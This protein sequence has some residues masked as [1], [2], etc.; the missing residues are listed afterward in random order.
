[1][2]V[3]T[4][5]YLVADNELEMS[6]IRDIGK[7]IFSNVEHNEGHCIIDIL[8][9]TKQSILFIHIFKKFYLKE[10]HFKK[11]ENFYAYPVLEKFLQRFNKME[12]Y[13]KTE[14]IKILII[15]GHSCGWYVYGNKSP[16]YDSK[17][18]L[19]LDDV[20]HILENNNLYLDA[21]SFD[22]C[23]GSNLEVI[24]ELNQ[25][26]RFIIASPE[27]MY[28][29]GICNIEFCQHLSKIKTPAD[30][31]SCLKDLVIDL[32]Q[33]SD[34]KKEPLSLSLIDNEKF[35]KILEMIKKVKFVQDD[36]MKKDVIDKCSIWI[37]ECSHGGTCDPNECEVFYDLYNVI[38]HIAEKDPNRIN[39]REFSEIYK[40][41]VDYS[42]NQYF[43][44]VVSNGIDISL[45][46][47]DIFLIKKMS[48]I[49]TFKRLKAYE[50]VINSNK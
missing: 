32:V 21:I 36:F 38:Q 1:M 31:H 30:V 46:F 42:Q 50:H 19:Y 12:E 8:V 10:L 9:K 6:A 13:L 49:K 37:K 43:K 7:L 26:T 20:R 11:S 22:S 44:G 39:F 48:Y 15:S 29:E 16:G 24:M 4:L 3:H 35:S 40:K 14:T 25:V 27:Y 28:W 2:V 45:A 23:F 5:Y 17:E 18:I 47:A 33:R 41:S 34:S